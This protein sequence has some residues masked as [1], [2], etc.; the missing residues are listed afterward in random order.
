MVS[1]VLHLHAQTIWPVE[2]YVAVQGDTNRYL[3]IY[4]DDVDQS[5][6][7]SAKLYATKP[8]GTEIWNNCTV[9]TVDGLKKIMTPITSQTLAVVG[10]VR[11]NI[12]LFNGSS[13]LVSTYEF[14]ITVQHSNFSNSAIP[15]S[16]EFGTIIKKI[17]EADEVIDLA[18]DKIDELDDRIDI[19]DHLMETGL[20]QGVVVSSI[21][22]MTDHSKTYILA[23]TGE[24]YYYNETESA[25]KPY[26]DNTK[27][28][29]DGFYESMTVG[30]AENLLDTK[31]IGTIQE[32]SDRRTSCGDVSIADDGVGQIESIRGNSVVFNQL[33]TQTS[34]VNWIVE[35]ATKSV[36]DGVMT[37]TNDDTVGT[38]DT[39]LSGSYTSNLVIGHKILFIGQVKNVSNVASSKLRV[40]GNESSLT[41]LVSGFNTIKLIATLSGGT[42][43]QFDF[44]KTD[45]TQGAEAQLKSFAY[46]DLTQIFGAGN[47]PSTVDDP[48]IKWLEKVLAEN[49][50]YNEGQIIDFYGMKSAGNVYDELTPN[51]AIQRVDSI[52]CDGSNDED[53]KMYSNCSHTFRIPAPRNAAK[54]DATG[55]RFFI[56]G[57]ISSKFGTTSLQSS[58]FDIEEGQYISSTASY[59]V[60]MPNINS[61]SD[62]R[63]YLQANPITVYYEIDTYIETPIN[64]PLNLNYKVADFGTE[65]IVDGKMVTDGFNQWD[66]EWES[67][68]IDTKGN[69]EVDST[70]IRSKNY[71]SAFPSTTYYCK[72]PVTLGIRFYD[73]NKNFISSL[74]VNIYGWSF[75]TPANCRYVR[76]F[77][78]NTRTYN[79]DICVNLSW[80]GY[81]NGEY[82]P[83]WKRVTDLHIADYFTPTSSLNS[84]FIGSI[85]YNDDFTRTIANLKKNFISKESMQNFLAALGTQLGGTFSMTWNNNDQDY[86]FNFTGG[87]T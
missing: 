17:Q 31:A 63:S 86:D 2:K 29:I 65:D 83:Y 47:E 24:Y 74:T 58:K 57:T 30:L 81:R 6:I 73:V 87:S 53:W 67:G 34:L 42:F 62:F 5:E 25:W 20:A 41:P 51:K 19:V 55:P 12:Q 28:N 32:I 1:K 4:V 39:Y 69:N 3:E 40:R 48:K 44:S 64:P 7:V 75:V 15:S 10:I 37:I 23:T 56:D 33:C 21:S 77:A 43:V 59:V 9:T 72:S 35:H 79:H 68:S 46:T 27:A 11:C 61:V 82:E 45:S 80:S 52:T 85:K 54:R 26:H 8:D 66:E 13:A 78:I 70:R 50:D 36:V 76:F 16:N 38:F 49:P 22:D 84:A 18:E 14:E 71:I 60:S